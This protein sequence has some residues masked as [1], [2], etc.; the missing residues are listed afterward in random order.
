MSRNIM[1]SS[2]GASTKSGFQKVGNILKKKNTG[3]DSSSPNHSV[4]QE[5]PTYNLAQDDLWEWLD[6]KFPESIPINV[7]VRSHQIPTP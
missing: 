4:E 1:R 3:T 6:K 7:M 5:F 2:T